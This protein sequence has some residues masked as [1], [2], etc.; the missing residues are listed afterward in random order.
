MENIFDSIVPSYFEI[1]NYEVIVLQTPDGD[2]L[3]IN[4]QEYE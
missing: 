1:G 4:I 2:L 3:T